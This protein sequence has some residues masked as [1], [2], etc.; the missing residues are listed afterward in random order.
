MGPSGAECI[1]FSR[2]GEKDLF[3]F[4][5]PDREYFFLMEVNITSRDRVQSAWVAEI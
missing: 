3:C 4:G 5:G 1:R 2:R